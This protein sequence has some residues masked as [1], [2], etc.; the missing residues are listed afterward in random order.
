MMM[1]RV[2]AWSLLVFSTLGGL[3]S[4]CFLLFSVWMSA[5]P[6][7]D[8][9]AWHTRYYERLAI[10]ALDGLIWVGSIVWLFRLSRTTEE[11]ARDKAQEPG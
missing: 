7:Y 9:P 5:H 4:V 8:S 3:I 1:R 11:T 2:I 6:R 10:T